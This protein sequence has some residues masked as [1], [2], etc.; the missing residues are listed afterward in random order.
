MIRLNPKGE[1]LS[2]T[3]GCFFKVNESDLSNIS[4]E[5]IDSHAMF[6]L[7]PG[8]NGLKLLMD[9]LLDASVCKFKHNVEVTLIDSDIH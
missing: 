1:N 2:I 5:N 3:G 6:F 7:E 8:N 4:F 9:S